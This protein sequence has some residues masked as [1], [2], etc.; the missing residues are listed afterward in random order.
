MIVKEEAFQGLFQLYS[1]R[2]NLK[3]ASRLFEIWEAKNV[4]KKG[5]VHILRTYQPLVE[6]LI[7]RGKWGEIWG[8]LGKMEKI[9]FRVFEIEARLHLR[10]GDI[11]ATLQVPTATIHPLS[12]VLLST[13]YRLCY[14]LPVIVFVTICLLSS[15][16][17]SAGYR[18]CY[19]LP[20]IDCVTICLFCWWC[21]C[22][23]CAVVEAVTIGAVTELSRGCNW[24]GR[25]SV[26][27][28]VYSLQLHH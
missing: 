15:L 24:T 22:C 19:Y 8:V 10:G 16:L 13:C 23:C 9:G 14:Y 12:T 11:P 3:A 28:P 1:E 7:E 5:G 17:L 4:S 27:L 26:Y 25:Y 21:Y 20:V 6:L 2:K 18:L